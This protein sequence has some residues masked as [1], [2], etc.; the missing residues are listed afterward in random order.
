MKILSR[1]LKL[2]AISTVLSLAI[3]MVL[4]G[5]NHPI[6]SLLSDENLLVHLNPFSLKDKNIDEVNRK[7]QIISQDAGI[8]YTYLENLLENQKWREADLTTWLIILITL[9][10]NNDDILSQ[11]EV[12]HI[13]NFHC[14]DL[15]RINEMWLFYS[16]GHF[17]FD[18]QKEVY[19]T[20]N[21]KLENWNFDRDIKTMR[22][23][24]IELGWKTGTHANS[25]G[26]KYH[27]ELSFNLDSPR[28]HLPSLGGISTTWSAPAWINLFSRHQE[29]SFS[30]KN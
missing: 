20:K 5:K 18:I 10:R 30:K 11:E 4:H 17:G 19:L 2:F 1:F 8:Y 6:Y 14:G 22:R 12:K 23:L 16:S 9:D 25:L 29:C 3:P 13:T 27:K 28:G 26:Y 7:S 24:A 15:S 21:G